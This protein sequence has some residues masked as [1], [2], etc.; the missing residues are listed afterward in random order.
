MPPIESPAVTA[1][2]RAAIRADLEEALLR[3][4]MA[5]GADRIRRA[6]VARTFVLRGV[7]RST[8]FAW[9]A[10]MIDSG[11]LGQAIAQEI[12]RSIEVAAI[13]AGGSTS[14][15]AARIAARSLPT[16]PSV[17]EALAS[18]CRSVNI[19]AE[20]AAAIADVKAVRAMAF[21]AEGKVR[22]AKL[23][24]N[25]AE[26]MRRNLETAVRLQQAMFSLG[27]VEQFNQAIVE[28]IAKESPDLAYRLV[29]R[30]SAITT[31]WGG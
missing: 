24:L 25:A 6:E 20:M 16:A 5:H 14:D 10:D 11:R 12:G 29:H 3:E 28:E 23:V 17:A 22:N 18:S 19:I 7:S 4:A 31:E 30:L 8:A 26:A 21:T 13:E 27:K 2:Q 9:I 1:E 15:A